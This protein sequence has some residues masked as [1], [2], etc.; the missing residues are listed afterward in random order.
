V[1]MW[2]P[3]P[4][5]DNY[6]IE[7]VNVDLAERIVFQL[8]AGSTTEALQATVWFSGREPIQCF[9]QTAQALFDYTRHKDHNV[10]GFVQPREP[11]GNP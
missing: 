2:M 8:M 11:S 4:S 6:A 10:F 9:A 3:I 1:A 5:Q 7:V